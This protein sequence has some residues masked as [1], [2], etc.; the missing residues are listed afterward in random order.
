[1]ITTQ[2]GT[3]QEG[4]TQDTPLIPTP[5]TGVEGLPTTDGTGD[6]P[7]MFGGI[8][9]LLLIGAIIWFLIFAPERKARKQRQEM[10][11]GIKKGDKVITTGG[12]H[13]QIVEVGESE[14]T[15]KSG[16]TRLKFSRSAVHQ[17]VATKGGAEAKEKS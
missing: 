9:P 12:L 8:W 1:M 2:E 5:G 10:I 6:A 16:D 15:I 17:V 11:D 14:V 13:G 4:T 7:S 3:T